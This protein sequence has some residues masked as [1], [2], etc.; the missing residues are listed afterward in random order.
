M[1]IIEKINDYYSR[2]SG[3]KG[4]IGKSLLGE[5]IYYFKVKKTSY[6][7][8]IV[9]YSIHA[10]EYVT[11]YLALRQMEDFI[12]FSKFG[13]VYFVPMLN[14]DGVKI[15]L[16]GKKEYKSNGRGVDLNVNFD[17][18]WG[19]GVTNKKIA[20][21]SDYIGKY[22]FSEPESRALRD[23]TLKVKPDFTI[24]YH[25][26]GEEIYYSFSQTGKRLER[27]YQL[28][29]QVES[30]TGYKIKETPGSCGGYKDWC[31]DKLKIP[32]ITI[33]VGSDDKVHPL[34]EMDA[35]DIYIKNRGL[36]EGI[37]E[38]LWKKKR[39]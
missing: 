2:F 25:S 37:S 33:E 31:I 38:Y 1:D 15:C 29:L 9:Q 12:K 16:N 27:D 6:P 34:G 18:K 5:N 35:N 10:R 4:I 11:S 14:P 24:S 17:A 21:D 19:R 3:E 32:S 39:Y 23:F 20:G 36:I 22:P 7:K 13:L 28:A 30:V 26:K 8:I